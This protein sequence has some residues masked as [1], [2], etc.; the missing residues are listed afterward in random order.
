MLKPIPQTGVSDGPVEP[1]S[2]PHDRGHDGPQHVAGDAAIYVSAVSKFSRC[3]A[4]SPERLN[5]EDVPFSGSSRRD[6]HLVSRSLRQI[7][8]ALRFFYTLGEAEVPERIPDARAPSKL[9][10][11]LSA[12]EVVLFLDPSRARR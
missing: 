5:L 4:K 1:S 8:C 9:S 12:D 10:V 6:G 2:P 7:V 3:F 11:V